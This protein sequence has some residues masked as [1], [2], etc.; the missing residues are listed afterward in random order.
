MSDYTPERLRDS[1][2]KRAKRVAVGKWDLRASDFDELWAVESREVCQ[3]IG[4]I[5]ECP[6][7]RIFH[8]GDYSIQWHTD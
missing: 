8:R 5:E 6:P 1:G 7:T 4:L 2:Y 3:V